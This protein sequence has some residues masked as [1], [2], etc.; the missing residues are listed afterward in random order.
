MFQ[1]IK[2]KRYFLQNE[3]LFFVFPPLKNTRFFRLMFSNI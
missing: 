1:K 3:M 2:T